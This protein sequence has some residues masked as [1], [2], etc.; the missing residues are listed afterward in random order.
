PEQPAEP[1]AKWAAR[2]APPRIVAFALL[3]SIPV[4][5]LADKLS[6]PDLWWHLKTGQLIVA[7]HRIPGVDPYSY[8]AAGKRWIVQEWGS[9]LFLYGIR[10]AFGLYGIL[11]YRAFFLL[12]I[13]LLVARLLVRRMGSGMGTWVLL[14]IVAYGGEPN[15]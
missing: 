10:K 5:M 11:A 2:L 14:A 3:A 6:D 7:T 13:Y 9:E 8:T 4:K 12:L 1:S 15:W